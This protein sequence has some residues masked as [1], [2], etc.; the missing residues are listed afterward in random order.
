MMEGNHARVDL[1]AGWSLA[2]SPCKYGRNPDGSWSAWSD[3][4]SIDVSIIEVA[5]GRDGRPLP[6]E[7]LLAMQPAPNPRHG[8]GWI[9]SSEV[10]TEHDGDRVVYRLAGRLCATNTIMSCWISYLHAEQGP[11][12]EQTLASVVHR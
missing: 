5:G 2:L 12:A 4:W 7:Q 3:A 8:D 11:F 10:L 1:W 6:A 9:G